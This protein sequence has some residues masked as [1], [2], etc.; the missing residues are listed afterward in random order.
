MMELLNTCVVIPGLTHLG[1]F[2]GGHLRSMA[3]I[4]DMIAFMI[5]ARR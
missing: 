2:F 5:W 1:Q 3:V 4:P